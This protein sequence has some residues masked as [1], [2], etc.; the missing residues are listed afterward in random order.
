MLVSSALDRVMRGEI[1]RLLI[2]MPPRHGKTELA[3]VGLSSRI[4]ALNPQ[5]NIMHGTYGNPLAQLNSRR[6]KEVLETAKFR[7]SC[8]AE[9]KLDAKASSHWETRQGG[10]FHAVSTSSAVTGFEC[11]IAGD[12]RDGCLI[13]DDPQKSQNIGSAIYRES[14][15]E[16]VSQMISSRLN[17]DD[18]PVIVIQQRLHADDISAFLMNGGTG[19][20]WHVLALQAL[21]DHG[22]PPESYSK[23]TSA[24][25]IDYQLEPG[26]LW[27]WRRDEEGLLKIRDAREDESNNEPRGKRIFAAQYQQEPSGTDSALYEADY[28]DFYEESDLPPTLSDLRMRIDTAQKG[29]GKNDHH[30]FALF[31]YNKR[32]RSRVYLLE[33]GRKR[34]DFPEL[35]DWLIEQI[36]RFYKFNGQT[37]NFNQI[38]IEDAN[39]AAALK[40][41]LAVKMNEKKIRVGLKLTQKYGDKFARAQEALP[42]FQQ[43]RLLV[44]KSKTK[45]TESITIAGIKAF[46]DEF[47]T[48]NENDT[49]QSDDILDCV[50]W[51]VVGEYGSLSKGGKFPFAGVL[52]N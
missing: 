18:T 9:V 27:P 32:D 31:G 28:L 43:R 21:S 6:V 16:N 15:K 8:D 33:A 48:F 4:F 20:D 2:N 11:G 22:R 1:K 46:R 29:T 40:A 49:H 52:A 30:A 34:C 12:P 10:T 26:A 13:I 25:I 39:I 47:E 38:T 24:K 36:E 35:V 5:A 51:E 17:H 44:P 19:D 3:V 37:I 14:T 7:E 42:Y 41:T 45:F 50:V 23:F